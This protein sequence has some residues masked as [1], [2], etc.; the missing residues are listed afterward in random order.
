VRERGRVK[1]QGG[2]P[3]GEIIRDDQGEPVWIPGS[4]KAVKAIGWFIEEYGIAQISM[5]LTDITTTP[6]HTAF[7]EVAERAAARG[8][9]V[10]GSEV[11]GLVPLQAMLDAGRHYLHRQRRSS[12][13]PDAELIRIAVKSMGLDDLGPFDPARKIIEYRIADAAGPRL[14][15]SSVE[16]FTHETASESPAPGGGSAAALA[17]ALGAALATMVANLA[18]HRRGWDDRWQEFSDWADRGKALHDRLLALID[19]DAAA[20]NG[21]L[22]SHRLPAGTPDEAAARSAAIEAATRRAVEVPLEVM[23]ASLEAFEVLAAMAADGP[24]SSVSD[25]GVGVLLAAAAVQGAGLNVRINASGLGP[26]GPGYLERAD[27]LEAAAAGAEADVLAEVRRR[28]VTG[29]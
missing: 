24:G 6:I 10:T 18:A 25:A 3:T 26:D 9:R 11:V 13:V 7:D 8:L 5:N 23:E 14:A 4:L 19:E 2:L 20:F 15:D 21:I 27:R 28:I 1:R 29:A 22:A 16:R 17:G 12:G